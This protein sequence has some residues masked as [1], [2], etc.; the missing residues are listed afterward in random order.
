[1]A[2]VYKIA[3]VQLWPKVPVTLGTFSFVYLMISSLL[4]TELLEYLWKFYIVL[5]W[6]HMI[7]LLILLS[8]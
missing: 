4:V 5:L 7:T 6:C 3:V 1:M 8:N 2:P